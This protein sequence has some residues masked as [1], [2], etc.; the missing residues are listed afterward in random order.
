MKKIIIMILI[1]TGVFLYATENT[2]SIS[3]EIEFRK[4]G[5]IY[6]ALVSEEYERTENPVPE[7]SLVINEDVLDM[8]AKKISFIFT[9][10]PEGVYGIRIFQDLN[11]N[12]MLDSGAFGPKEPWGMSNNIHPAFRGPTFDEIKFDVFSNISGMNIILK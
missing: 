1:I 12:A 9:D 2:F 8:K 11:N 10:I 4:K 5:T 3:G 7:Y 6:I